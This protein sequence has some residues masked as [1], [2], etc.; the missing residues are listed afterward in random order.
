VG[1]SPAAGCAD[2]SDFRT[3]ASGLVAQKVKKNTVIAPTGAG[4]F[5]P[6]NCCHVAQ[7]RSSVG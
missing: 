7:P 1:R 3:R 4:G 2:R 6:A 5:T